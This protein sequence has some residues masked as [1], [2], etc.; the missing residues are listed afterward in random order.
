MSNPLWENGCMLH[1]FSWE[2]LASQQSKSSK[3]A[4]FHPI[5]MGLYFIEQQ[6]IISFVQRSELLFM[7]WIL[8]FFLVVSMFSSTSVLSSSL[9]T[10]SCRAWRSASDADTFVSSDSHI[11]G[12]ATYLLIRSLYCC[13]YGVIFFNI[14]LS[15]S[16]ICL[17]IGWDLV[18]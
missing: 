6:R 16:S 15:H 14:S 7:E 5:L 17:L 8:T 12:T 11:Y 18:L 4:G 2:F 3:A 10:S 1:L 9:S 13:W